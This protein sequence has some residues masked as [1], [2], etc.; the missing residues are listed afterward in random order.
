[1][2]EKLEVLKSIDTGK[3]LVIAR[4]DSAPQVEQKLTTLMYLTPELTELLEAYCEKHLN[5]EKQFNINVI[6]EAYGS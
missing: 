6:N 3:V 2:T 5:D 1:M 4:Q